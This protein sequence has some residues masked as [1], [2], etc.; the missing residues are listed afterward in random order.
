[1]VMK[2]AIQSVVSLFIGFSFRCSSR[3]CKIFYTRTEINSRIVAGAITN[4]EH[5]VASKDIYKI[6]N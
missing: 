1:M 5:L 3:S 6:I 2:Q 4:R